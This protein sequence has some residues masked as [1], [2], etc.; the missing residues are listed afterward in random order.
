MLFNKTTLH[1]CYTCGNYGLLPFFVLKPSFVDS[2][3]HSFICSVFV[4]TFFLFSLQFVFFLFYI[5]FPSFFLIY[6]AQLRSLK[7]LL[8]LFTTSY[9]CDPKH[10][11]A[12]HQLRFQVS[13]NS[14]VGRLLLPALPNRLWLAPYCSSQ[15]AKDLS[16]P[17]IAC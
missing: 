14:Y 3:I 8:L 5:N 1:L 13:E 2:F 10:C 11:P 16:N 6:T 4:R 17:D 15:C 12:I 7:A 9:C